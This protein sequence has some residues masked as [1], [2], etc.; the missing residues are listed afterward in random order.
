MDQIKYHDIFDQ[1]VTILEVW[2]LVGLLSQN[3]NT[4][5]FLELEQSGEFR[6]F[7]HVTVMQ[8]WNQEKTT[9]IS[10]ISQYNG[11]KNLRQYS[12]SYHDIGIILIYCSVLVRT[13]Q[14][15]FLTS[16]EQNL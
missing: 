3:I 7:H 15:C 9:L 11:I 12:V 4:M 16:G 8:P 14:I 10:H 13:K 6:K 5:R 2:L 1:I